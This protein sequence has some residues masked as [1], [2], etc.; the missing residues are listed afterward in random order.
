MA[1]G[2]GP[3]WAAFIGAKE[4]G[5]VAV[6]AGARPDT[7]PASAPVYHSDDSDEDDP[8]TGGRAV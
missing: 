6:A 7:E 1:G 2:G 5:L 3:G 8:Y 4:D